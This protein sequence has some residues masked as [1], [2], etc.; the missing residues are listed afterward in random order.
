MAP[1]GAA[2][3]NKTKHKIGR[4]LAFA[5]CVDMN[6]SA[7]ISDTVLFALDLIYLQVSPD[8]G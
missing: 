2:S 6:L 4:H 5:L 1:K 7:V 8:T 3:E